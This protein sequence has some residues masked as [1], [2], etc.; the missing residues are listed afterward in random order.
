ML[1]SPNPKNESKEYFKEFI[2]IMVK[3]R[4][5]WLQFLVITLGEVK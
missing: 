3:T 1:N 2:I 4:I 5:P